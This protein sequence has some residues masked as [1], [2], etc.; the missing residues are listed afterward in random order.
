MSAAQAIS[1]VEQV[2]NLFRHGLKT[3]ATKRHRLQTCATRLRAA[4]CLLGVCLLAGGCTPEM[5]AAHLSLETLVAQHNANAEKIP[6]LWAR[7]EL[8]SSLFL[9]APG[10]LLILAKP[11]DAI[12]QPGNVNFVMI[13]REASAEVYRLGVDAADGIYY[14]WFGVNNQGKAL[15][16]KVACAGAPKAEGQQMPINPLDIAEILQVTAL[17]AVP[18]A[19][20]FGRSYAGPEPWLG[21]ELPAVAMTLELDR[22]GA[23]CLA[24]ARW[25]Y[26][27]RYVAGQWKGGPA[28]IS[29]EVFFTWAADQPA[30]AYK[31]RLFDADG[32][33]RMVAHLGNYQPVAADVAEADRPIMPTDIQ[34][35][36][37]EIKNV[38]KGGSLRVVLSEMTAEKVVS[39]KVFDFWSHL[40]GG[41]PLTQIDSAYGPLPRPVRSDE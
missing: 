27:V 6:K 32:L 20:T 4:A 17:P 10:T 36:W 37:P 15:A 21:K 11:A 35:D 16:G 18:S 31:V 13:G 9:G 33:C 12:E 7:A 23:G 34:M 41:L 38:Q 29:R 30:R 8:H 3:R 25:A 28:K 39:P 19:D 1:L 24:P 14:F 5:P 26:V 40:P 2:C 22:D